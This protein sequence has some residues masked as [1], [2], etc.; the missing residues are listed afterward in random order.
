[1]RAINGRRPPQARDD[2]AIERQTR[3]DCVRRKL[4]LRRATLSARAGDPDVEALLVVRGHEP[5]TG[6]PECRTR[7]AA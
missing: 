2:V 1:M 4:G 6:L 7:V 5:G 3:T